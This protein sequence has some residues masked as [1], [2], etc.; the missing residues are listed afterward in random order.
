[1]IHFVHCIHLLKDAIGAVARARTL[2][3]SDGRIV[4]MQQSG[5]GVPRRLCTTQLRKM[6]AQ[7]IADG[8]KP[9][10]VV[11]MGGTTNTGAIDDMQELARIARE[12][13]AFTL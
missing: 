12:H 4:I 13:P 6:I 5:E 11:G 3:N 8:F 9:F 2:L 1:M 10:L 7:D